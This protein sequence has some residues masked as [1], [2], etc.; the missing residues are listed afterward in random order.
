MQR[1]WPERG[2]DSSGTGDWENLWDEA[3]RD[4]EAPSFIGWNSSYTGTAIPEEEMQEWL[5]GT[6][7]RID[8]FRPDR[9]L[10]IGCGVGLILQHLAP[11]CGVYRGTD[12]S[13]SA[14]ADLEAW[15]KTQVGM[16]HVELQRSGSD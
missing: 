1:T 10:E 12:I 13:A 3:Y 2:P 14:I 5:D 8:G 7:E 4:G 6:V 15:L 11:R 9:V 16:E